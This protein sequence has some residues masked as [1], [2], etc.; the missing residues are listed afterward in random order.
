MVDFPY[1]TRL[2]YDGLYGHRL[3]DYKPSISYE[4][5]ISLV[6]LHPIGFV[7]GVS[8]AEMVYIWVPVFISWLL[9]LTI[10]KYGRLK[11]YRKA[12]PFFVGLILGD[13]TMG[14]IWSI[15]NA[16]FNITTYNMGWHPVSW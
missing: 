5:A 11:T 15:V 12:I 8:P 1:P 13:Y 2:F 9:K 16:T 4:N 7:L 3:R 14:G 10:L 6:A